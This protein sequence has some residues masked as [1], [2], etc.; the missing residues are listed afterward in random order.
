LIAFASHDLNRDERACCNYAMKLAEV[1]CQ[2]LKVAITE[3]GSQRTPDIVED[4][5]AIEQRDMMRWV[6]RGA[7][8]SCLIGWS[9]WGLYLPSRA[10]CVAA[11]RTKL[12]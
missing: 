9:R 7:L 5:I 10:R 2:L 12:T 4:Q 11:L 8:E 1:F 6:L 3:S